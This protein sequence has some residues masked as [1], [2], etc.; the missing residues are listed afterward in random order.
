MS[1]E[2]RIIAKFLTCSL[3]F[4]IFRTIEQKLNKGGARYADPEILRTLRDYEAVDAESFCVGPMEGK[5]VRALEGTFGLAGSMA[6]F[7]KA[8]FT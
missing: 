1:R 5:A 8:Q 6:A 4:M 3:A 7:S 2:D